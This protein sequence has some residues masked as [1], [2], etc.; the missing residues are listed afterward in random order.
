M[1]TGHQRTHVFTNFYQ[2]CYGNTTISKVAE[3]DSNLYNLF[4]RRQLQSELAQFNIFE[5]SLT[6]VFLLFLLL[7]L[8]H[9]IFAHISHS[10]NEVSCSLSSDTKLNF[11]GRDLNICS[12]FSRQS[13]HE[14]STRSSKIPVL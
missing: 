11:S 3:G 10:K 12:V 6:G 2:L 8:M 14:I 9:T 1:H 7:A 5:H 13:Q 4:R